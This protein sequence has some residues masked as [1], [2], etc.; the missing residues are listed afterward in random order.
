[1]PLEKVKKMSNATSGTNKESMQHNL[2]LKVLME[3][4]KNK[5]YNFSVFDKQGL[6]VGQVKDVTLGN[7]R[8]LNLVIAEAEA[9]NGKREFLLRSTHIQQVDSKNKAVAVDISKNEIYGLPEYNSLAASTAE[10]PQPAMPTNQ[11]VQQPATEIAS[12]NQPKYGTEERDDTSFDYSG[13]IDVIE[14]EVI[15]LLEERLVVDVKNQKLGDVVIRKEVETRIVRV[16]IRREKLIVE[17]V[18]IE[19][20]KLAEID[21][22]QAEMPEFDQTEVESKDSQPSVA[23]VLTS[24]RTASLLLDAIAKQKNHGCQEVRVEIVLDNAEHQQTFQQWFDRCS[25]KKSDM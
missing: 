24:P 17:Q 18:G 13:P 10:I 7:A 8:Q 12:S 21:L 20:K 23:G 15:R 16:P 9:Y 4:L 22:G 1:M 11:V 6:L 5:L 14:E 3:Q 19:A 2:R 25:G